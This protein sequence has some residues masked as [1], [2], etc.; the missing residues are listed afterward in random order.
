M[1]QFAAWHKTPTISFVTVFSELHR[2]LVL[3]CIE[4]QPFLNFELPVINR[5]R[6]PFQVPLVQNVTLS[7]PYE[8]G[9][10]I[11]PGTTGT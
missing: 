6:A 10:V 4:D 5:A 3:L 11:I 2:S 7:L 1:I 9:R 8:F